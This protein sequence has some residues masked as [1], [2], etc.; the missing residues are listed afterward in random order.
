[1]VNPTTWAWLWDEKQEN[2]NYVSYDGEMDD[3]TVFYENSEVYQAEE[4][5]HINRT[6]PSASNAA[7]SSPSATHRF[8]GLKL[9]PN[10][11]EDVTGR[12]TAR[13]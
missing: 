12:S 2:V 5:S 13:T 8:I 6:L 1:M 4:D 3:V 11:S 9:S 10:F 7:N